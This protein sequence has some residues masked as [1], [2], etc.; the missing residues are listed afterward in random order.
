MLLSE[1]KKSPCNSLKNDTDLM[2]VGVDVN[3]KKRK[4]KEKNDSEK[5]VKV[6]LVDILEPIHDRIF[7]V[8]YKCN[9][10]VKKMEIIPNPYAPLLEW[11]LYT[12][13]FEVARLIF[14]K[15]STT[16]GG[17]ICSAIVAYIILNKLESEVKFQAVGRVATD[18]KSGNWL[19]KLV[20]ENSG[21]KNIITEKE[22]Y[23]GQA[24]KMIDEGCNENLEYM[25]EILRC[26]NEDW[27]D[28]SC[29]DLVTVCF[30][31]SYIYI[32][33]LVSHPV[34][35]FGMYFRSTLYEERN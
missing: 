14:L 5:G 22:Y 21:S 33:Y 27:G 7:G 35:I 12:G 15:S 24:K 9:Y 23:I 28:L 29:F 6:S 30:R 16:I 10:L 17:G 3:L 18:K 19:Y 4:E 2:K 13:R 32:I 20:H 11:C 1:Y 34:V 26:P 31:T 8:D 25:L